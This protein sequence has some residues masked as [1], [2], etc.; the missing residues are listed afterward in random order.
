MMREGRRRFYER[1]EE[2][3]SSWNRRFCQTGGSNGFRC[4]DQLVSFCGANRGPT[5]GAHGDMSLD[6]ADCAW[7]YTDFG[8]DFISVELS[9]LKKGLYLLFSLFRNE[10]SDLFFSRSRLPYQ[11]AHFRFDDDPA[12]KNR[13]SQ[14]LNVLLVLNSFQVILYIDLCGCLPSSRH[15]SN[16]RTV[17]RSGN[18]FGYR[19]RCVMDREYFHGNH[20]FEL[21]ANARKE[22]VIEVN[23]RRT[24]VADR[25][26]DPGRPKG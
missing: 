23:L 7:R 12:L 15:N 25:K 5:V 14:F 17:I 6:G 16:C 1:D 2:A 24:D 26:I 3:R 18:D 20:P 9:R 13:I 11:F 19:T 10:G 8:C 4:I 22:D 21:S